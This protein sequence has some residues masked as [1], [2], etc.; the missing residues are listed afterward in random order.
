MRKIVIYILLLA[1][2]LLLPVD[3]TDVG[4]LVPVEVVHLYKEGGALVLSTDL[5]ETGVGA[6]VREAVSNLKETTAG[7]IFL[8]TA[9]YLI[10]DKAAEQEVLQMQEYLKSS[11]RVCVCDGKM[12]LD[13]TAAFLNVHRP[14]VK[15]KAY[16]AAE[17]TQLLTKE[18]GRLILKEK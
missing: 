18:N 11:V 5:G 3:G 16:N 12:D 17:T 4:K 6:T 7:I 2:A 8:D 10:V 13:G 14:S 15:L 9:N 1:A